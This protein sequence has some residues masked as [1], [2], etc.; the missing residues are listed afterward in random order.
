MP[1]MAL[2]GVKTVARNH[3]TRKLGVEDP[4]LLRSLQSVPSCGMD[5]A[6]RFAR[7]RDFDTWAIPLS[8][9][10]YLS[11]HRHGIHG[12]AFPYRTGVSK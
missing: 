6:S 4:S 7:V 11:C 1:D 12:R 9:A 5:S 3:S 10:T 8:S 2:H